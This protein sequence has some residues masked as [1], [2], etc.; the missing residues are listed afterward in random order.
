MSASTDAEMKKLIDTVL[1]M[2]KQMASLE[3]QLATLT[4][5]EL[6]PAGKRGRKARK[7]RDPDAPK[8]EPNEWIRFTQRVRELLKENDLGF[9]MAKHG[10]AFA[11]SLKAAFPEY[12]CD[13][14]QIL[15]ARKKWPPP[16]SSGEESAADATDAELTTAAE[17]SA[18]DDGPKKRG[19]K[20]MS[21]E[22][23]AEAKAAREAAKAK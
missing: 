3:A 2:R 5:V 7:P 19:R 17:E 18:T 15:A 22:Q 10:M 13:D 11:K 21:A 4:G 12:G 23:K 8:R 1:A 9:K 16:V 20:P 6:P 14:K